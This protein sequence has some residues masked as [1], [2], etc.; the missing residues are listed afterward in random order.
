MDNFWIYDIETYINYFG[1]IFKNVKTKELKEFII[2]QDKNDIGDLVKFICEDLWLIG[3]N[4]NSF[5]DRIL[6]FIKERF[7]LVKYEYILYSTDE[8]CNMINGFALSLMA[9]TTPYIRIKFK[10]ID[11]MK[12]GNAVNKSLKLVAVN[13]KWKKIQDLPIEWDNEI[14]E[15]DLQLLHNYNLNDVEITEALYYKLKSQLELRFKISKLY[16]VNVLSETDSGIANRLLE[17]IYKE[18]SGQHPNEFKKL[19]TNR[20]IIH[21]KNVVFDNVTFETP[22]L[23]QLLED[24]KQHVWY[25]N[26]KFLNKTVILD[27][28]KYKIGIGGLHSDDKGSIFES[29]ENNDIVDC[30]VSSMYPTTIIDNRLCPAHL[31]KTFI[32]KYKQIKDDR[33]KAKKLNKSGVDS[34]AMKIMLVSTFGKTLNEHHW[35]YDPLVGLQ[36]TVNGQLYLLMLIEDLVRSKFKVISANTDGIITIVPKNRLSDYMTI[37]LEWQNYT[38]YDLEY[39]K[40]KKYI[41][42]DVNNYVAIKENDEL[43]EKGFFEIEIKNPSY[44]FTRGFD[45]PIVS[46][47]VKNYFLKDIPIKDTIYNHKDIYDFCIAQRTDNKFTNEIYYMENNEKVIKKLQKSNRWYVSTNGGSFYKV[48]YKEDKKINYCVNRKITI[49]NDYIQKT[50]YNIDYSYYISEAQKVINLIQDPQLT[51]F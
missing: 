43:K 48:D 4:N 41:R 28:I 27:G 46:I 45:K 37:C 15:Q 20:D 38:K 24:I 32:D 25:K 49:F 11:L 51:L 39:T 13:L 23:K 8:M 5:D 26:Q 21:F 3:Y 17:K 14:T 7:G 33:S 29:D 50:N 40:Y 1:V 36:I 16:K 34:E 18:I 35:L 44:Q 12:V 10:S 6:A 9:D 47:A 19:R 22:E 2:F 31:N 42:K 30:D